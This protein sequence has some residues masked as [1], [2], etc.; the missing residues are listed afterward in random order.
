MILVMIGKT[1]RGITVT[2]PAD[3]E[4]N[5]QFLCSSVCEGGS[6]APPEH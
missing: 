3:A 6:G 4:D 2:V 1:L 5:N